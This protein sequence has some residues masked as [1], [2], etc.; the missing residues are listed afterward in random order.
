MTELLS[1]DEFAEILKQEVEEIQETKGF[2][3]KSD[4]LAFWYG[5]RVLGLSDQDA[6]NACKFQGKGERGID[7]FYVDSSRKK[8]IIGQAEASEDLD[9]DHSFGASSIRKL[10]SALSALANPEEIEE[11]EPIIDAVGDYNEFYL[12]KDKKDEKF[13]VE[14]LAIISGRPTEGM[15]REA[16]SFSADLKKRPKHTLKIL[17]FENLLIEYCKSIEGAPPPDFT[18]PIHPSKAEFANNALVISIL[19]NEIRKLVKEKGLSLFE[20]NARLP[21]R[22]GKANPEIAKQLETNEKR[23]KFWYLNNGLTITCRSFRLKDRRIEVFGGQIVNGCQTAWTLSKHKGELSNVWVLAKIIQTEDPKFAYDI[24]RATNLQTAVTLRDL[25]SNDF[26]QLKLQK[27]FERIGYFYERKK[28]EWNVRKEI[29]PAIKSQYPKRNVLDNERLGQYF[30]AFTGKPSEAK[31]EKRE[32]FG[33]YYDEIFPKTRTAYELLL[34]KLISDYLYQNFGVGCRK[35]GERKTMRYY[36][37][38]VGDLT[39]LALVGEI[40]KRK[41]HP[42]A[43]SESAT[44]NLRFLVVRF[45]K[46]EGYRDFFEK[47]DKVVKLLLKSIE[48]WAKRKKQEA[49]R[50][51]ETWDVR[52]LHRDYADALKDQRIIKCIHKSIDIL[53]RL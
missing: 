38:T 16:K 31:E 12:Q 22:K 20:K 14:L 48:R 53:P 43:K 41:Y 52:E 37:R 19:G 28:N 18:L 50:R 5:V 49:E 44:R 4:A 42:F 7:L 33:V 24:R 25:R 47:Y 21:L 29:R 3:E 30:L 15:K 2:K 35:R 23:E 10:R 32:I 39:V 46:P 26:V 34:P 36:V 1:K 8:I 9:P 11:G 27:S 13:D 6:K 40:I 17:D 45:E 51:G